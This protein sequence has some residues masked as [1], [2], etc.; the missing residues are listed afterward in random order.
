M[1]CFWI[2]H[3]FKIGNEMSVWLGVMS[4]SWVISSLFQILTFYSFITIDSL[5]QH[6]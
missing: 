4:V 5:R 2:C 3:G 6:E 1:G